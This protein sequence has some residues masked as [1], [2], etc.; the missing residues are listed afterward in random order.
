MSKRLRRV[1]WLGLC[2][3]ATN[4]VLWFGS[5]SIRG[6][7]DAAFERMDDPRRPF[8]IRGTQEA[9][10]YRDPWYCWVAMPLVFI[11]GFAVVPIFLRPKPIRDTDTSGQHTI[12]FYALLTPIL[13]L[14]LQ[15][16]YIFL[17]VVAVS[18]RGPNWNFYW[19]AEPWDDRLEVLNN[20]NVSE[21]FWIHWLGRE[22]P[23]DWW[24]RE[25][26]GIG[27][28]S[29]F[30]AVG[31]LIAWRLTKRYPGMSLPKWV[32]YVFIFQVGAILPAKMLLRWTMDVKYFV[33]T[34]W[35]NL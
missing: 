27:A 22:L 24:I 8:I 21:Y 19:P 32:G 30:F 15:S 29:L 13:M 28:V 9:L 26:F 34:H 6:M 25:A 17:L 23:G 35:F 31:V 33:S 10:V 7:V 1:V 20:L 2:L 4:L 14:T 11:A 16:V 3:A 5:P 12:A 18:M